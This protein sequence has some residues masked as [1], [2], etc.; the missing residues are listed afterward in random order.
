MGRHVMAEYAS[1][2]AMRYSAEILQNSC[3]SRPGGGRGGAHSLP[4][5]G[6]QAVDQAT[7][8]DSRRLGH[9]LLRKQR[10]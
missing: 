9:V 6:C 8:D 3:C 10:S 2:C 5:G 7:A 1:G 4:Q